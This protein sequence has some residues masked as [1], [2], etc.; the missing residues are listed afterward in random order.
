MNFTVTFEAVNSV[1][2]LNFMDNT[3]KDGGLAD[4]A[5]TSV[6][7][8]AV[9]SKYFQLQVYVNTVLLRNT[10]TNILI[11]VSSHHHFLHMIIY[12]IVSL[13]FR[14][15]MTCHKTIEK[16]YTKEVGATFNTFMLV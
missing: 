2:I 12:Q 4:L 6:S 3:E 7:L 5:V 8:S 13:L 14:Q 15:N 9:G 11:A 10:I 1:E 16:H